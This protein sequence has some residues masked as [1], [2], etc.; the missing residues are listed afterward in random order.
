MPR[1]LTND[2]GVGDG[3]DPIDPVPLNCPPSDDD[4]GVGDGV[5]PMPCPP[6]EEGEP[7]LLLFLAPTTPPTT[8]IVIMIS[9]AI[10]I[11]M[12]PF[13]VV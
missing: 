9:R 2:D 7:L 5:D 12:I 8:A 3:V 13:L 6:L 11:A 1:L 4:D 10:A